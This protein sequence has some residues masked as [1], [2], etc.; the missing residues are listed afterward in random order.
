LLREQADSVR[1]L[2]NSI[3]KSVVSGS[4]NGQILFGEVVEGWTGFNP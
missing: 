4:T 3:P 1:N 2:L